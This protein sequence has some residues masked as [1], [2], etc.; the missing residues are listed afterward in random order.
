MIIKSSSGY[1]NRIAFSAAPGEDPVIVCK[2]ADSGFGDR[3]MYVM[4]AVM[5]AGGNS[6]ALSKDQI[7]SLVQDHHDFLLQCITDNEPDRAKEVTGIQSVRIE[8]DVYV[9]FYCGGSGLVPN[10]SYYGFY[11][12][13]DDLPLAVDV[14]RTENL[15]AEG[16]GF[17]WKEPGG[18]GGDN[19]YYTERIMENWYYYESHY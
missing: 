16:N 6:D 17:G 14:T 15:K 13:P 11:Y 8:K 5:M 10:S 4:F 12:S 19:W 1:R 2:A 18:L 3:L 7:F 9:E